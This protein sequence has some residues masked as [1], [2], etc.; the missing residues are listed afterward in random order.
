MKYLVVLGDGMAD[1][2]MDVLDGK[3]PLEYACTPNIDRLAPLSQIGLV[4]T[5]PD[6][7]KPGSDVANLSVIGY[8]PEKYYSGRSPLEALSIGVDMQEGDIAVR[9]N[10][11][12][13]SGEDDIANKTMV[14]YSAGEISTAEASELIKAVKEALS[15]DEFSFYAGVSYRH[16]MIIKNGTTATHLT[17][18]HD[19]SGRVIGDYLPSGEYGD[20]LLSLIERSHEVLKN[21]PVNLERIKNGK[22]PATHVWFWGAG[23]KPS[24]DNFEEKYGLKGAVISAVDLLKGIA[25]GAGMAS[26]EVEGATGTLSTNW[27]GKIEVAK[28]C[29][30][31]GCDYVYIHMEAPDECGHQGDVWGKVKAIEKV[32]YVVGEMVKYLETQGD[33]TMVITPDHATPIVKKT[34]TAEP[35]PYMIYKSAKPNN[36]ILKYNETDAQS[37]EY[38]SSGQL[39]ITKMLETK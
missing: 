39:I 29:F 8:A 38:L 23:T 4:K 22:N 30:E 1:Y 33:F 2:K 24:L 37:G 28:K 21:H 26:P 15:D 35:I 14:D 25:I 9:T 18:P 13:L 16:C 12:T 36:G 34:H 20:K 31:S 6:G 3:T 5:V 27:D 17:P 11:V 19:I 32:D 7:M 10:L